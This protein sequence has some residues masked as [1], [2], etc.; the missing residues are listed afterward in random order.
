MA[1]ES[2]D[3]EGDDMN[4]PTNKCIV[5]EGSRPEW[6]YQA[7][8][9]GDDSYTVC[10]GC[11][12]EYAG[13]GRG[14]GIDDDDRPLA[15]VLEHFAGLGMEDH[16]LADGSGYAGQFSEHIL[17]VDDRGFVDVRTFPNADAARR[18]MDSFENDGMGAS[19][20]DAY[21]RYDGSRGLSVSFAGK[22]IGSYPTL[23]RAKAC[24]SVLMRREGYYP[25]VW[26]TH[27]H[28][29]TIRRISVW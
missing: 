26:L 4:E 19:E 8:T 21:I 2:Y 11:A 12:N 29:P 22:F 27:E 6:A 7:V 1:M 24:V 10:E 20:D 9:V 5:C 14:E 15:A 28:G 25:N 16:M 18:E 23:R 3:G 13:P 17:I